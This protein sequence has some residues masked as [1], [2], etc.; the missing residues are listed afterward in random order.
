MVHESQIWYI[1]V[2]TR[3]TTFKKW[4]NM[5]LIC[6]SEALWG[7]FQNHFCKLPKTCSVDSFLKLCSANIFLNINTTTLKD[8]FLISWKPFP[9]K[10]TGIWNQLIFQFYFQKQFVNDLGTLS[11]KYYSLFFSS[12]SFSKSRSRKENLQKKPWLRSQKIITKD[13]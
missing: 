1:S 8:M 9:L 3:E 7:C 2:L 13:A 5:I 10:I 4:I 12:V 11:E 6:N